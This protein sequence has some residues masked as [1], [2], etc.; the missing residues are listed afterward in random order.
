[1]QKQPKNPLHGVTLQAI[2]ESLVAEFG[3]EELG[4]KIR[5]KCFTDTPSIS[6]SLTFIRKNPW[7]REKV[8]GLYLYVQRRAKKK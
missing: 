1:M 5:I 2:L 6:S 8:E 3:F 7:A 4:K